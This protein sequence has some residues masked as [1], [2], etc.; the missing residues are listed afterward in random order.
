MSNTGLPISVDP[1]KYANQQIELKGHM[2]FERLP[3]VNEAVMGHIGDVCLELAFHR[4]EQG[5]MLVTG[6]I[7]ATVVLECQRC[8][9]RMTQE[10]KPDVH[11]C[12]VYNDDQ[13]K[14]L[15][16][17]YDPF[18]MEGYEVVL[19]DL[20]EEELLLSIPA[21]GSHEPGDCKL[22]FEESAK[23]MPSELNG[24]EKSNPFSVLA[25]FK[26]KK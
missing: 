26:V 15:P 5:R 1:S 21:F 18:I 2:S 4:D 9:G 24:E 23:A 10:L 8:L 6:N 20:V 3:R 11:L 25:N 14:N 19:T 12:I 17:S 16:K 13:A 22:D 7:E